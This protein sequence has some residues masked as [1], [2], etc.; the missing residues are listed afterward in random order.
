MVFWITEVTHKIGDNYHVA[1]SLN[2]YETAG[3]NFLIDSKG[4]KKYFEI[5]EES[6]SD[7]PI[8]TTTTKF[9]KH[10]NQHYMYSNNEIG[11]FT[12]NSE[13]FVM[14]KIF[15]FIN[16]IL[17]ILST[18]QGLVII[19]YRNR[20]TIIIELYD[21]QPLSLKMRYRI[22]EIPLGRLQCYQGSIY[23]PD[24]KNIAIVVSDNLNAKLVVYVTCIEKSVASFYKLAIHSASINILNN[25]Y[26]TESLVYKNGVL[27][28]PY[29]TT[30]K[31]RKC[32]VVIDLT[33]REEDKQ[34]SY[35]DGL[36]IHAQIGYIRYKKIIW[37]SK[38]LIKSRDIQLIIKFNYYDC[39]QIIANYKKLSYYDRRTETIKHESLTILNKARLAFL[40]ILKS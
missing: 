4:D 19:S 35:E 37:H 7:L 21:L 24:L 2:E 28:V 14:N 38:R 22:G 30:K 18:E 13:T 3:D 23:N 33:Q 15:T 17:N 40:C 25:S 9:F 16:Q 31:M 1:T 27:L 20:N 11:N 36:P 26:L 34:I 5:E 39:Y 8:I 12:M 32:P 29:L 6:D 10:D